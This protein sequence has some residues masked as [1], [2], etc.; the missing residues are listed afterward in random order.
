[1]EQRLKDIVKEFPEVMDVH[2]FQFKKVRAR[3]YVSCHCTLP[4][5]CRWRVC[6][7]F[8]P[9][10]DPFKHDAPECSGVLIHPSQ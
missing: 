3:L 10:R 6:T 7:T 9:R 2:E 4:V 1:L 5:I 8:R